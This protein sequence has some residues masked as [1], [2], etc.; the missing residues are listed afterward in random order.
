M[1]NRRKQNS[2]SN[3]KSQNFWEKAI[4]WMAISFVMVMELLILALL[5][6][7]LK[8]SEFRATDKVLIL[9]G[10]SF[11]PL[12]F[13]ILRRFLRFSK[14][15]NFKV[16]DVAVNIDRAVDEKVLQ[17][18]KNLEK[19]LEGKLSKAEEALYPLIGGPN[20]FA[21]NRLEQGTLIISSKDFPANIVVVKL[22]IEFLKRSKTSGKFRN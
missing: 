11:I 16:G 3:S 12:L 2:S 19:D 5:V 8:E 9:L 13:E 18:T 20:E 10:I 4:V 1:S 7:E 6:Q 17:R 15:L 22:L 21:K 14:Y